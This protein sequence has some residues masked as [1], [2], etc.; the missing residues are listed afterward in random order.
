MSE[1]EPTPPQEAAP[2]DNGEQPPREKK[3]KSADGQR[4]HK[5][6]GNKGEKGGKNGQ[7]G[8]FN[9]KGRRPNFNNGPRRVSGGIRLRSTSGKSA[10]NWWAQRWIRSMENLVD[11]NRLRRGR[12]YAQQGQVLTI[13]EGDAEM[14]AKVQG[15]RPKPYI[16]RISMKPFND[17]QWERLLDVLSD[18]AIFA[19]QLLS[20]QMPANIED[21][22][23]EAEVS[24]FPNRAGELLTDCTCPDW[25][26]PCKHVA[27]THYILGDRFDD[28]PFLLFRLRGRTQEQ[29]IE[30]LRRHRLADIEHLGPANVSLLPTDDDLDDDDLPLEQQTLTLDNE[31]MSRFWI[32]DDKLTD[33]PIRVAAPELQFPI[34][35][36]LGEPDAAGMYSL[37]ELLGN[38]YLAVSQAAQII[39]FMGG[40][41]DDDEDDEAA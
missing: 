13:D 41:M 7:K 2:I 10:R 40:D 12:Y 6:R 8:G 33:F 14:I 1:L 5:P 18:K 28:D 36:R 20:G 17:E 27:A 29:I 37:E 35:K 25:A 4:A 15:S 9:N 24:L 39:A 19:A 34:I 21:A 32:N 30:G 22:F 38:A 11:V 3:N 23:A 26:N 31:T 16:V